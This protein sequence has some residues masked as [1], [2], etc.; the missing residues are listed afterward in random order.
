[1]AATD[2]IKDPN[3]TLDWTF[4]WS[5]WLAAL[6]TISTATFTTTAGITVTTSTNTSTSATVWL[7][8]GNT[9]Q[10][11]SVTSTV[12]TSG[13]RTDERSITIRVQNR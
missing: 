5:N 12:V 6:E 9:G 10:I 1:M 11:Y 2:W 3:S 13:G 7:S 4:D 8:G